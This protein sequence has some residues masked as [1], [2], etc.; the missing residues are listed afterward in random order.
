LSAHAHMLGDMTP[1]GRPTTRVDN[2]ELTKALRRVS[3]EIRRRQAA[4]RPLEERR[5]ELVREALAEGWTHAQ[6]AEAT[7]LQRSRIG[8]LSSKDESR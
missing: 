6:V 3:K 5:N 7:G 1:I 2:P 8:Q 4:L